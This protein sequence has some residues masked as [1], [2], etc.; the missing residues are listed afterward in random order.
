MAVWKVARLGRVSSLTGEPFPADTPVITALFGEEEEVGEDKVRGTGFTR[1]DYREDEATSELL[2]NAFCTWC[3]RTPPEKMKTGTQRLDLD[4]ARNFLE[5][6]LAEDDEARH[7]VALA[8]ALILIRKR[9]LRLLGE[10]GN[11][12]EVQWPKTQDPF[13]IPAPSLTEADAEALEQE[14]QRLF[15]L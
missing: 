6:L 15:D 3:T 13:R 12:L 2:E 8:L 4:M 11:A 14:L 5:R 9:R 1:R 7:P 10:H